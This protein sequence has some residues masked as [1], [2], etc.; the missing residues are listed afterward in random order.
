MT[1]SKIYCNNI[2]MESPSSSAEGETELKR[3][4]TRL[5][6][7]TKP[8]LR[9]LCRKHKLYQTPALNDVLYLHYQGIQFIEELEEY[10][11]LKCLWLENNAI[12][13]IEGLQNQTKLRSLFLHSNLIKQIENLENCKLLDT[14][15]LT[16]NHI[17]K[18]ENIGSEILPVLNTLYL[19]SNYLQDAESL[20]EL[21]SCLYLSVLD[22]SDNR[23]DDLLAIKIFS[24][25]PA[26]RVLVLRGNPI[27]SMLP[28]YRKTVIL[29]CR[30][31]TYLDSRPVFPKDRACAEAW[32]A[33]GYE[34]E[35]KEHGKW[36]RK[37]HKKMIQSINA[38]IRLRN[39]YSSEEF[40]SS[41]LS[42][43]STEDETDTDKG[44]LY[45]SIEENNNIVSYVPKISYFTSLDTSKIDASQIENSVPKEDKP[46][47]NNP[48]VEN[49]IDNIEGISRELKYSHTNR[50]NSN[51]S[52]EM[53]VGC[54]TSE[55]LDTADSAQIEIDS[56]YSHYVNKI[57][58][59][60]VNEFMKKKLNE[61]SSQL[62]YPKFE[63]ECETDIYDFSTDEKGDKEIVSM[64][65]TELNNNEYQSDVMIFSQDINSNILASNSI[66]CQIAESN[67]ET[68]QCNFSN[69]NDQ[70]ESFGLKTE[71]DDNF[72]ITST[73]L[74]MIDNEREKND[75]VSESTV[76]K[77][78]DALINTNEL[79]HDNVF[80]ENINLKHKEISTES[81]TGEPFE[82]KSEPELNKSK[83]ILTLSHDS[84]HNFKK[85]AKDSFCNNLTHQLIESE[86]T[87]DANK[88][89]CY[90]LC[91]SEV[92]IQDTEHILSERTDEIQI[93]NEYNDCETQI[94]CSDEY[95]HNEIVDDIDFSKD[96]GYILD[97]LEKIEQLNLPVQQDYAKDTELILSDEVIHTDTSSAIDLIQDLS[98]L[99]VS[100]IMRTI[101]QS[102]R[103]FT[104]ILTEKQKIHNSSKE[105]DIP[106]PV[107]LNICHL[108]NL[109]NSPNLSTFNNDTKEILDKKIHEMN[110]EKKREIKRIVHRVYKQKD[111]YDDTLEVVEGRLVV[112]K[113]DTG[114]IEDLP[115]VK[116]YCSEDDD[117][118]E[119]D[120][121][122]SEN[123]D[124]PVI[125]SA[126]KQKLQDVFI[127]DSVTDE[128]KPKPTIV[129]TFE[130]FYNGLK[131]FE[132]H[133]ESLESIRKFDI[134]NIDLDADDIYVVTKFVSCYKHLNSVDNEINKAL[135]CDETHL[136]NMMLDLNNKATLLSEPDTVFSLIDNK[137]EQTNSGVKPT[138]SAESLDDLKLENKQNEKKVPLKFKVN[139]V[140]R[141]RLSYK[142][143]TIRKYIVKVNQIK[144]LKEKNMAITCI[145][146][147][148]VNMDTL[149]KT[150]KKSCLYYR[151]KNRYRRRKR[152]SK[153]SKGKFLNP[154]DPI[155]DIEDMADLN[156]DENFICID[157]VENDSLADDQDY[158]E[159]SIQNETRKNS[160]EELEKEK[161]HNCSIKGRNDTFLLQLL[162][163]FSEGIR[164]KDKT[165]EMIENYLNEKSPK[166]II[167]CQRVAPEELYCCSCDCD[168]DANSKIPRDKQNEM[169]KQTKIHSCADTIKLTTE[170]ALSDKAC[171]ETQKVD[172]AIDGQKLSENL[173]PF[174]VLNKSNEND[175]HGPYNERNGVGVNDLNSICGPHILSQKMLETCEA[176]VAVNITNDND[177]QEVC[178]KETD[179]KE[180]APNSIGDTEILIQNPSKTCVPMDPVN[181]TNENGILE[182]C[183]VKTD[184]EIETPNSICGT[185]ILTEKQSEMRLP[186]D[187]VEL[188]TS[189]DVFENGTT[190]TLDSDWLD[191]IFDILDEETCSNKN[192]TEI[193]TV[194]SKS[195]ECLL[196]QGQSAACLNNDHVGDGIIFPEI[197]EVCINNDLSKV[198]R[199]HNDDAI[200]IN[201]E[202]IGTGIE[203]ELGVAEEKENQ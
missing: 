74:S 37:E 62:E 97:L 20:R 145:N 58:A 131:K 86:V 35:N 36:A 79:F 67:V 194:N 65:L 17:R 135:N 101:L 75:F 23:I 143:N 95:N 44:T 130:R 168:C 167:E 96:L 40:Q 177:I 195:D 192:N 102:F 2:I 92:L 7:I 170:Q 13:K 164:D 10:T 64:D 63:T 6:R 49:F 18:I 139:A 119:S 183:N 176:I 199:I 93:S 165:A 187:T 39:K 202:N 33:G 180:D 68:L 134:S 1:T 30:E 121:W 173:I 154:I 191:D 4:V 178:K 172:S 26:L 87:P 88:N 203:A 52:E 142:F 153:L 69:E 106:T 55:T 186:R 104:K 115:E 196:M 136:L 157:S 81:E 99:N 66:N 78:C 159:N 129:R 133:S 127:R 160:F 22:L 80:N 43:S 171:T 15:N 31:L 59:I 56:I 148:K 27:V 149:I 198:E 84:Q 9:E 125:D 8:L 47:I 89:L 28:Q 140:R 150:Q 144:L 50:L 72:K 112:I 76:K 163:D 189:S 34:A 91:N 146:N 128:C 174:V 156:F 29:E 103:I 151:P 94:E 73:R 162:E 90:K 137:K 71:N 19:A 83:Q 120:E 85:S 45:E 118:Y 38:S 190:T 132:S 123:N 188:K 57:E 201:E 110:L 16:S 184:T 32:L 126:E 51:Q 25:M 11:E 108:K 42:D 70:L 155:S 114:A 107:P 122:E 60:E 166:Q 113:K 182:V 158:K 61:S 82:N 152:K 179:L 116:T 147:D 109:L 98:T 141:Q 14:L 124:D 3:E 111:K 169:Q 197:L 193:D 138:N 161:L 105:A 54:T 175:E 117:E 77:D 200:K 181:T 12:S 5:N 41:L 21:E 53:I 48:I 100:E 185:H 46:L 24:K